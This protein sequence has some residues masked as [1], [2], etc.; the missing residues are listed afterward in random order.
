MLPRPYIGYFDG[1][2][3]NNLIFFLWV[4]V[5]ASEGETFFWGCIETR[6]TIDDIEK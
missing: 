6:I 1:F 3:V 2:P 5:L 4:L